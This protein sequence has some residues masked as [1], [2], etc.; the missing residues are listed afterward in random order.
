MPKHTVQFTF[1]TTLS[2]EEWDALPRY[3]KHWKIYDVINKEE[4]KYLKV[5]GYQ[6]L[7]LFYQLDSGRYTVHNGVDKYALYVD[8]FGK[9]KVYNNTPTFNQEPEYMFTN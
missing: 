1:N 7:H 6:D 3:K 5:E 2:P 8:Q 9:V 4:V